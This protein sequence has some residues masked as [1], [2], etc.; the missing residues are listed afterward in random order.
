MR[1]TSIHMILTLV[2]RM[3]LEFVQMDI[4][5]VFLHRE[6]NEVIF[7]VQPKGFVSKGHENKFWQL[8]WSIY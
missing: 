5:I 6:L 4:K 7:M 1:F 8:K 2:T 3:D